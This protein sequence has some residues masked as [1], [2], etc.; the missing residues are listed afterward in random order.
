MAAA[1]SSAASGPAPSSHIASRRSAGARLGLSSATR[2]AR[3]VVAVATAA[4]TGRSICDS[5]PDRRMMMH[6]VVL[7]AAAFLAAA[8]EMVE[9]LTIVLAVAVTRGWRSAASGVVVALT[10]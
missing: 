10:A 8:V 2:W 7:F 4:L 6:T 9:A 3:S 1:E 5:E